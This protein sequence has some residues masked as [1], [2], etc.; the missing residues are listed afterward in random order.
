MRLNIKQYEISFIEVFG[1]SFSLPLK[2]NLN[3]RYFHKIIINS[4][5]LSYT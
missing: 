1:F 4:L 2:G 5:S 3:S